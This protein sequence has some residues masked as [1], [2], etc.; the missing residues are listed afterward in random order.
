MIIGRYRRNN[1]LIPIIGKTADNRPIPIIGRLSADYRCNPIAE[2]LSKLI[3]ECC[4]CFKVIII[5]I[6][7]TVIMIIIIITVTIIIIWLWLSFPS[8][9]WHCWL[10]NRKGIRPVKKLGVGLLV[11]MLWLEL[12]MTYSSSRPVVTTTSIIL[13]FNK[14]RLTQV[15]LENDR[16]NGENE[17][18]R[19]RERLWLSLVCYHEMSFEIDNKWWMVCRARCYGVHWTKQHSACVSTHWSHGLFCF[20]SNYLRSTIMCW[21]MSAFVTG[22]CACIYKCVRLSQCAIQMCRLIR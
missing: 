1:W 4:S 17:R 5:I 20:I 6:I 14:H 11:V 12:C 3:V 18:E 22:V 9:L 7:V 15:H 8:V 16:S 2:P 19:K 21:V 10:G 13:C